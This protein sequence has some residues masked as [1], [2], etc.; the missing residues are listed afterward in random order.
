M[1][2]RE[3]EIRLW[4]EAIARAELYRDKVTR[5]ANSQL[6][7]KLEAKQQFFDFGVKP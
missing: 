6:G 4:Q 7:E 3:A 1:R 5:E 2:E